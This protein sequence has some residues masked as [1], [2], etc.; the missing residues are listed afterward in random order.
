MKVLVVASPSGHGL[1]VSRVV[2]T[3]D[4]AWVLGVDSKPQ[5]ARRVY[6]SLDD[7]A[8]QHSRSMTTTL[9]V[10]VDDAEGAKALLGRSLA[11]VKNED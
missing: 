7:A 10:N 5:R 9:F 3:G 2:V 4:E 1:V 8:E 11:D 6:A